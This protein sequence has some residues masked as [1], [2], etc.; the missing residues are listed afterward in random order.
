[1]D[2]RRSKILS[3]LDMVSKHT[4]NMDEISKTWFKPLNIY[5][6]LTRK[7]KL[8]K[9]LFSKISKNAMPECFRIEII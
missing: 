9:V 1:M 6:Y 2:N 5:C 7:Y 3:I 4:S 8:V